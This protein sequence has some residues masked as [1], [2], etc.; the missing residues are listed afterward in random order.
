MHGHLLGLTKDMSRAVEL[1]TKAAELGSVDAIKFLG[2]KYYHGH[3][4]LKK[5]MSRAVEL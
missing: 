4:G 3:L 2:D 1:W 5:D